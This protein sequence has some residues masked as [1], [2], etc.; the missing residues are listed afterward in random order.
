MIV[1]IAVLMFMGQLRPSGGGVDSSPIG[2]ASQNPTPSSEAVEAAMARL[3]Q[4]RH[5]AE[6][7]RQATL[8]KP[9]ASTARSTR[10]AAPKR[11]AEIK[12]VI[13]ATSPEPR[14]L[15]RASSADHVV[16]PGTGTSF[17]RGSGEVRLDQ[18]RQQ[19]SEE[20]HI[21]VVPELSEWK[22]PT[23][24]DGRNAPA[25]DEWK[26]APIPEGTSVSHG[27]ER[28]P[29]LAPMGSVKATG[30]PKAMTRQSWIWVGVGVLAAGAIVST[31]AIAASSR[32]QPP[33][34]GTIHGN[35]P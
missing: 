9:R 15:V 17:P 5:Q 18:L 34:L 20:D 1:S 12:A 11:E 28:R 25:S 14:E 10:H 32:G 27:S 30:E 13:R 31:I 2:R 23:I 8:G 7:R 6:S 35:G 3:S 4:E 22:A 24:S 16:G 33:S 21:L 19:Q 29:G 26:P